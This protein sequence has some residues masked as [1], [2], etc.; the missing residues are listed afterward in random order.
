MSKIIIGALIAIVLLIV[1]SGFYV[2]GENAR[3]EGKLSAYS[4]ENEV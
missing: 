1:G 4:N 2:S 3:G